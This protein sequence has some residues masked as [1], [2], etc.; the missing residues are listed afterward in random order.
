MADIVQIG[1]PVLRQKAKEVPVSDITSPEV[2][3]VIKRMKDT[4]RETAHGVAI[5]APQIGESLRIFVIAGKVFSMD[6]ENPSEQKDDLVCINPKIVKQSKEKAWMDEGCLS[7]DKQYGEAHRSLKATIRAYDETG[8]QFTL[9]G[10]GLL[11][12]AFQ[13]ETDH[14]EGI[15]FVD[16]ARNVAEVEE[17][18]DFNRERIAKEDE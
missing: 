10:S 13:H 7:V 11:A 16:H 3:D 17:R 5:A 12:H 15:L 1:D 2:Q 9:G 4:L 18:P 14:L 8:K 6:E